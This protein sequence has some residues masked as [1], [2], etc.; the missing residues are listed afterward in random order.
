MELCKLCG[1]V[2]TPFNTHSSLVSKLCKNCTNDIAWYKRHSNVEV[3]TSQVQLKRMYY[4]EQRL[5]ASRQCGGYVPKWFKKVMIAC[6]CA[7]CGATFYDLFD[8]TMC[9]VCVSREEE[10][11]SEHKDTPFSDRIRTIDRFYMQQLKAGFLVPKLYD[12]RKRRRYF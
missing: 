2:L 7:Y 8:A 1:E 3:S 6:S 9:Q 4:I 12:K 10:Y 11:K 5:E